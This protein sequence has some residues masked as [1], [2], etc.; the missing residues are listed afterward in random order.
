MSLKPTIRLPR[1]PIAILFWAVLA[2]ASAQTV[3]PPS[4]GSVPGPTD[5]AVATHLIAP[6]VM[7]DASGRLSGFSVDLWRAI[8][9]EAGL[10][11][12]FKVYGTMRAL[13]EAVR[14]GENPVGVAAVSITAERA[15]TVDFSQPIYRSGMQ[16]MVPAGRPGPFALMRSLL[17][18][19]LLYAIGLILVGLVAIAHVGWLIHRRTRSSDWKVASEYWPGI[20]QAFAWSADRV[21][22]S[23][24]QGKPGGAAGWIFNFILGSVGLAA[25]ASITALAASSFTLAVLSTDVRSPNDLSGK[26]VATVRG[27]AAATTLDDLNAS[28]MLYPTFEAAA[29]ALARASEQ[30]DANGPVALVYDAP[31]VAYF[32]KNQGEGRFALVGGPFRS[33]NYG[34]VVPPE[35]PLRRPVNAALLTLTENG[36]YQRIREKWFGRATRND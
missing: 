28:V 32:V 9:A 8:A 18:P 17:S 19:R 12:H 4:G 6:F 15:K 30:R 11:S 22:L 26:R 13:L 25:F 14:T 31:I 27:S 24:S 23:S 10:D 34:I 36:A 1:P 33:E 3:A 20:A 35:S 5:L 7:E 16:I 2:S 29:G 21:I